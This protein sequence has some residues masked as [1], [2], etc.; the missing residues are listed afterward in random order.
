MYKIL[1]LLTLF[2]A[3]YV[4]SQ[5]KINIDVFYERAKKNFDFVE[6]QLG[7]TWN[8]IKDYV[9][10][11]LVPFGKSAIFN[12]GTS[13]QCQHGQRE[14]EGNRVMSCALHK[15][16]DPSTAVHFVKCYMNRFIRYARRDRQEFGESCVTKAGLNW[17][18]DVKQCYESQLGT[19]L[20]LNAENQT[21][22]YQPDFIPTIVYNKVFDQGLQDESLY[23][24]KSTA[25]TLIK[26]QYPQ[27]C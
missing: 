25:C 18:L 16:Q 12:G 24:F 3:K 8:D 10:L 17:N 13:V 5:E 15:I 27:A 23:N 4:E 6:N 19:R 22:T 20:Q 9:N 14:C 11:N 7:P 21:N 26:K 2:G 1:V